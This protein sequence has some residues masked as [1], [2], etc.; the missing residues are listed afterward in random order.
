SALLIGGADLE[1]TSVGTSSLE[2]TPVGTPVGIA[3]A[4]DVVPDTGDLETSAWQVCSTGTGERTTVVPGAPLETTT[5]DA[6]SGLVVR[7]PDDRTY[8]VWQGSRLELDEDS[9]A[10]ESLGY[11]AV[12]PRPVSAAFLDALVSGPELA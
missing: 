4:P 2:G 5:I 7:G 9:G 12:T 6:G 8:L 3:G 10:A 1:T 11:G